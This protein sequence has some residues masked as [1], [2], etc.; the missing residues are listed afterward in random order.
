[1]IKYYEKVCFLDYDA[2][3]NLTK[4]YNPGVVYEY[5]E[6]D[7]DQQKYVTK[8]RISEDHLYYSYE[9]DGNVRIECF[10]NNARKYYSEVENRYLYSG[11]Y[12]WRFSY[13][14]NGLIASMIQYYDNNPDHS[15]YDREEIVYI[16]EYYNF[17]KY[18]EFDRFT[19]GMNK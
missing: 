14:E 8:T 19:V 3:G 2:N 7:Y 5:E 4:I 1:M 9:Y 10:K 11:G 16:F 13:D 12:H 15:E 18:Y 6:F 17:G